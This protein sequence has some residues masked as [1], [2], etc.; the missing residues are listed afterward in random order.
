MKLDIVRAWKDEAY[1]QS[2]SEDMLDELPTNPA[3]ELELTDACLDAIYGGTDVDL[4]S[5][6]LIA[7]LSNI[8]LFS[9]NILA[10]PLTQTCFQNR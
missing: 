3:G 10:N 6:A 2:L 9:V 8:R 7:V 5:G 4:G 1:R